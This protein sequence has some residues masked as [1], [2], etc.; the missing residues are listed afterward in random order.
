ME[1]PFFYQIFMGIKFLSDKF[2][3]SIKL[4][5]DE[6]KEIAIYLSA[7]LPVNF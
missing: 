2:T 1:C 7:N 4:K 6:I 5:S 3:L